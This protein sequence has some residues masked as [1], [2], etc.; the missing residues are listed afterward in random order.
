M[1]IILVLV[2]CIFLLIGCL[3]NDNTIKG[4]ATLT[5]HIRYHGMEEYENSSPIYLTL[6][7][8]E[9]YNKP[10]SS[11]A[12]HYP[13]TTFTLSNLPEIQT[14]FIIHGADIVSNKLCNISIVSENNI[15]DIT[16]TVFN[17]QHKLK[18]DHH[19]MKIYVEFKNTEIDPLSSSNILEEY[20]C[21]LV[22]FETFGFYPR[23]LI[24]AEKPD[25]FTLQEI[26]D[27]LNKDK[28]IYKAYM[29][30]YAKPD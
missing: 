17:Y 18:N 16:L 11:S 6:F 22:K 26:T 23:A 30:I 1:K 14:D 13:D 21:T 3:N 24:E 9:N 2:S 4:D 10:I 27:I 12:I 29:I 25:N 8:S 20:N 28:R 5:W 19:H 15:N 7:N